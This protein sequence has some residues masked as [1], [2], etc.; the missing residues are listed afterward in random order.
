VDPTRI[1]PLLNECKE[2][3]WGSTVAIPSFLGKP[4][5]PVRLGELWMGAYPGSPS[6]LIEAAAEDH[7]DVK[8][9][10]DAAIAADPQAWLGSEVAARFGGQLPFLLKVLAAETALSIQAHPS[11]EQAQA[12]F[13]REEALGLARDAPQRNYRDPHHKPELICALTP[14]TALAR[15]REAGEI[16]ER[17][18]AL[19]VAEL[20]PQ[21]EKLRAAPTREVLGALF[22]A[23]M[24]LPDALHPR[25]LA[26]ALRLAAS[27]SD[28]A[29]SWVT[30]LHSQYPGDLGV[31][32]P[33]YLN[34]LT[35]EPGEALFLHSREL[36]SYLSGLAVELMANSDNVLR[37]GLTQSHVDVPELL[38]T[39][40]YQ[41]GPVSLAPTTWLRTD[42][43]RYESEAAEFE[44]QRL[45]AAPGSDFES[46]ERQTL[47][48]LLCTHG[49]GSIQS[50][51]GE[52]A[53]PLTRGASVVV[54]ASVAGF[55]IRGELEL[56]A[57]RPGLA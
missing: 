6:R 26:K 11:Q 51:S 20:G 15:F 46:G 50:V 42:L 39:L 43:A 23:L 4:A 28:P 56:Y 13:A 12:G 41:F 25:I 22:E 30:K 31:L 14:F 24:T 32:A 21:I 7:G 19:G 48:I 16:A 38:G 44:L 2:K 1:Y 8:P 3:D 27:S 34:V 29:L 53:L 10:L 17:L 18:G 45:C 55:H 49:H 57:A 9:G 36:H 52:P 47:E 35:L 5:S 40:S 54:P 37:G 33:L